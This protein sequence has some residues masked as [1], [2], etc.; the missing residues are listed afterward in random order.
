MHYGRK[1][2]SLL[3]LTSPAFA[4]V[5][6]W[7]MPR[8]V[9]PISHE[10]YHLHMVIFYICVVIG[11]VVFSVMFY[12]MFKH[13]KSKGVVPANF[14]D[15]LGIEI[16]WTIIPALIL[17]AMA[18]PATHVLM[19]M[20]NTEKA[21]VNVKITGYQWYWRYDYLD[22]NVKFYSRLSTPQAQIQNKRPKGKWYL[23]EVDQPLVLPIH[24]KIR[25]L[26]TAHDVNH[27]WWVPELG[28]KKDA[29]PGM[30]NE[31]W[32]KIEK[33]G[34]YRGKCT[35]LCGMHHGYMPIV[36]IGLNDHDYK[37]WLYAKKTGIKLAPEMLEEAAHLEEQGTKEALHLH[38]ATKTK[39]AVPVKLS[40]STLIAE[41]EAVYSKICIACHQAQG[42]GMPPAF[43]AIA[44]GK[45]AT[46]PLAAHIDIIL[47]GGKN[48]KAM[49]AF[50]DQL[51]DREIAAVITYQRNSFGNADKTK[52]GKDA[53]GIIQ[54][55]QI[56]Q[57]R[58]Q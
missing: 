55:G 31:A 40:K 41:G 51:T 25:F 7:N 10:I 50:R 38:N 57:A 13:R 33:P 39:K 20:H 23:L 42:Q 16:A 8:G 47:N 58:D 27:S 53:G 17:I 56:K 18:I 11:A 54:P 15:H 3:L 26:M 5:W 44:G 14:H 1:F 37:E 48:N 49:Q 29:L 34:V 6:G 35:E 32:A 46:G 43:P 12:A 9:T 22:E 19:A 30:I 28:V 52:Y 21:A 4:G 24:K 36:V 45:I 2:F